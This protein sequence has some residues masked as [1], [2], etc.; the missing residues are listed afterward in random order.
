MK[1][2]EIEIVY[3]PTTFTT[4]EAEIS[5]KTSEFFS[6]SKIVRIIGNALPFKMQA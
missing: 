4:A 3:A 5:F 1:V 2:T 6:E